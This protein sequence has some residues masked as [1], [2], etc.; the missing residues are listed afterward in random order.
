MIEF[1]R[2]LGQIEMKKRRVMIYFFI[3]KC[4]HFQPQFT[5]KFNVFVMSQW[6]KP[7]A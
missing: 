3:E 4:F 2:Q 1:E 7:L 5:S 6:N